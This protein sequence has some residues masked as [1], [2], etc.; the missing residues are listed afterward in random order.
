MKANLPLDDKVD[1][2]L[3]KAVDWIG[4]EDGLAKRKE[5]DDDFERPLDQGEYSGIYHSMRS[6]RSKNE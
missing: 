1:G 3:R 5:V 6:F 4:Q 2:S